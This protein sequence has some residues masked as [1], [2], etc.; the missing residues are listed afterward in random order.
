MFA[1]N[2]WGYAFFNFGEWP[3]W[4]DPTAAATTTNASVVCYPINAINATAATLF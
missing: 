3:D 2:T 4:A 1:A